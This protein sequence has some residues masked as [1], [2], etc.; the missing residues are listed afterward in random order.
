MEKVDAEFSWISG[1][2]LTQ[3]CKNFYTHTIETRWKMKTI[4]GIS[5]QK[6]EECSKALETK[7]YQLTKN[8]V[9]SVEAF[10]HC[11]FITWDAPN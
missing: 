6:Q 3:A 7:I 5:M 4:M 2:I 9:V 10:H 11:R 1:P 8:F